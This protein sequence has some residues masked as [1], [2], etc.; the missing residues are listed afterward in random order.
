MSHYELARPL[1]FY[2]VEF[3]ESCAIPESREYN[4][5]NSL[6]G[7]LYMRG[8]LKSERKTRN[9]CDTCTVTNMRAR[10]VFSLLLTDLRLERSCSE[11]LRSCPDSIYSW[12]V[13][14]AAIRRLTP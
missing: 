14:N 4:F 5:L 11:F 3:A 13:I 9:I 7:G 12:F 1:Q 10:K 6:K 8:T 2:P